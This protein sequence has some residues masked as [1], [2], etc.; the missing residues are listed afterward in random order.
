MNWQMR[1]FLF[2]LTLGRRLP[3]EVT[4]P[5]RVIRTI[6]T[7]VDLS[8][9]MVLNAGQANYCIEVQDRTEQEFRLEA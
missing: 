8:H 2:K 3:R 7:P 1:W 5:V 9:T 4:G 6:G